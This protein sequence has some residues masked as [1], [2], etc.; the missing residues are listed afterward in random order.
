MKIAIVHDW[1]TGMR[2]GERCLEVFCDL[3]PQADLFS[4]LHIPGSISEKI[5]Q[6]SISTSF[7]QKFPKI[8]SHYRYYLPIMPLAVKGW[9]FKGYDLILS[10]SHCV[11]KGIKV[12]PEIP[13]LCYCF[14]PMRYVWDQFENYFS[15]EKAKTSVRW[16]MKG[17]RPWLRQWDVNTNTNVSQFVAISKFVQKR[18]ESFYKREST[19]LYP[20]VDTTFFSPQ[21]NSKK[22][23]YLM[24][25][26]FAPYKRV[27]LAIKAFNELGIPLVVIGDGQ[28]AESLKKIAN[29]NIKFLGWVS[30]EELRTYYEQCRAIIF[31]A[32]EDFGIVPL[33]AQA[34][35]SPVICY[36]KGGVLE[37]VIPNQ[38]SWCSETEI[39]LEKTSLPTGIYFYSQNEHAIIH[40]VKH[41]ETVESSFCSQTLRK[42]ALQFDKKI[43]SQK[44]NTLI[45][46]RFKEAYAK[47]I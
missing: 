15:K 5:E 45:K 44:F 31:P 2:G 37:T 20:P 19:V 43:F 24:V 39:P 33:E 23:F 12:P 17:L 38:S 30:D 46:E 7:L 35:G 16:V 3:F 8:K 32:E 9:D 25:S 41:F 13:H 4:L 22:D 27:D 29:P 21:G 26:A 10:S 28:E 14:T 6:H 34:M 36:G 40:A 47:E 42:H 18:I 1:L 11:A